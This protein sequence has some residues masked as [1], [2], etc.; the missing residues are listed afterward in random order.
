MT[1]EKQ[2]CSSCIFCGNKRI[3]ELKRLNYPV[4]H[5]I[6]FEDDKLIVTPDFVGL[7]LGHLLIIPK[8]HIHSFGASAPNLLLALKQQINE[9]RKLLNTEDLFIFEHGAVNVSE[10]GASIDHAHM[11]VMPRPPEITEEYIDNFIADSKLVSSNKVS[12]CLEGLQTL[13][14]ESQSYIYYAFSVENGWYYKVGKLPHQ[15]LRKMFQPIM[16]ISYDWRTSQFSNQAKALFG[17]TI[18]LIGKNT[19]VSL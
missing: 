2:D 13:F 11:H 1:T 10:G 18:S 5:A 7:T 15:F 19:K 12:T 14:Q 9:C 8:E 3:Q 17:D 4:D 16:G 6:I